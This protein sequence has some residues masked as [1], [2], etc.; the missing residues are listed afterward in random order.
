MSEPVNRLCPFC[1]K[2]R[3]TPGDIVTFDA[4]RWEATLRNQKPRAELFPTREEAR[5]IC[6]RDDSCAIA[7]LTASERTADA[8]TLRTALVEIRLRYDRLACA[9]AGVLEDWAEAF[10]LPPKS[11]PDGDVPIDR[12]HP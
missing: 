2:K 1:G 3:A 12:C 11:P 5:Y 7:R 8:D 10:G 9:L 4:G 6:W